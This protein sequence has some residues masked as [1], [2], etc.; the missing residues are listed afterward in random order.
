MLLLLTASI[1]L[2]IL[3]LYDNKDMDL[4]SRVR[5]YSFSTILQQWPVFYDTAEVINEKMLCH[6]WNNVMFQEEST[7]LQAL[8][9]RGSV[10]QQRPLWS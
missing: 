5:F 3:N 4:W 8:G 9:G 2:L 1:S 10:Y 7:K 6:L